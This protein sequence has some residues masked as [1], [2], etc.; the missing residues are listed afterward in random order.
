MDSYSTLFLGVGLIISTF[1]YLGRQEKGSSAPLP[2]GPKGLP[3]LG[4]VADL[5][6]TQP[7][8]TFSKFGE[9]YGEYITFR[10]EYNF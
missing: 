5:P 8:I 9:K 2:P 6:Q 10:R 1:V 7:W 4:N 3:F